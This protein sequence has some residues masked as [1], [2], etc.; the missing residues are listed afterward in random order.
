MNVQNYR[1]DSIQEYGL[2]E[3]IIHGNFYDEQSN[4][5]LIKIIVLN[6]GNKSTSHRLL[7]LLHLMFTDKKKTEEK[8]KILRDENGGR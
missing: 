6:L 2:T 3:K 7:N 4:Y 1:T 5:D 8:E